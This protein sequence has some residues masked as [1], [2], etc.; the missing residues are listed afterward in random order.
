MT[1]DLRV[2]RSRL[3]SIIEAITPAGHIWLAKT[4]IHSKQG[5]IE[6]PTEEVGDVVTKA[7][8]A[9]MAVDD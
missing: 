4:F 8:N 5:R 9:G 6:L 2:F 1:M 7:K 3:R